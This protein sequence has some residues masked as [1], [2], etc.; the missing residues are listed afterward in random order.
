MYVISPSSRIS[1]C[2]PVSKCF[3]LSQFAANSKSYLAQ[4]TT[5]LLQPGNHTL[6]SM[7]LVSN[8]TNL[9]MKPMVAGTVNIVC[10]PSGK[11]RFRMVLYA[12]IG[13]MFFT[14]CV[15]NS[16]S[17]V[18]Y[19]I[20]SR[21]AFLGPSITASGTAIHVDNAN[22]TIHQCFF[23]SYLYGSIQNT[24]S[25]L[26]S[27]YSVR[28]MTSWNGG[29]IIASRSSV[30]IDQ[31]TF[32]ENRA[33]F[34]G[35]I[36]TVES[37]ITITNS[38]F[39]FNT[40][41]STHSATVAGGSAVCAV[42]SIVSIYNSTLVKNSVYYGYTLGGAL[43]IISSKLTIA[44]SLMNDNRAIDSGGGVH[45]V[46]SDVTMINCTCRKNRADSG[47]L[48]A[49]NRSTLMI[50]STY[51]GDNRASINGGFV[52]AFSSKVTIRFTLVKYAYAQLGGVIYSNASSITIQKS[53]VSGNLA[54]I[55]GGVIYCFKN[56]DIQA[57]ESLF[58]SNAVEQN[59][60]VV[61][62]SKDSYVMAMNCEF[63]NNTASNGAVFRSA[64]SFITI[65]KSTFRNN[66]AYIEG[67][68]IAVLNS[69]LYISKT[70]FTMNRALVGGVLR[71]KNSSLILHTLLISN[72]SATSGG[73]MEIVASNSTLTNVSIASNFGR[74][75]ILS[76]LWSHVV[77]MNRT[78][79][80]SNVGSFLAV[81][82]IIE[83]LGYTLFK[84]NFITKDTF[85]SNVYQYGG[86]L[87]LINSSLSLGGEYII[88]IN[89]SAMNGGAIHA[90][91]SKVNSNGRLIA[92]RNSAQVSGGAM[93]LENSDLQCNGTLQFY[94]N[95]ALK[96]GGGIES[97]SSSVSLNSNC[98]LLFDKNWAPA[99]SD[100]TMDKL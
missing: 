13:N 15:D 65:T 38:V 90:N 6:D 87:T 12:S 31:S 53:M 75:G 57:N 99:G 32:K 92:F 74:K 5:L 89:N 42:K 58:T 71:V 4:N 97:V 19:L 43:A 82:S 64:N 20:L 9:S 51:I 96:R 37:N 80:T 21:L 95:V 69:M 70:T 66:A 10:T 62:V 81:D 76:L 61:S 48:F 2:Q 33:Q 50:L 91:M 22:V 39:D 41:N 55:D 7:L 77:F 8:I 78:V 29:A 88:F 73:V 93:Y 85:F 83:F 84:N 79:V 59:G 3:T 14:H 26:R 28:D 68:T 67:G 16:V 36:Y 24:T 11:L 35:A 94:S 56:C 1:S 54:M 46:F 17:N 44:N 45:A 100:I 25:T 23:S 40:A 47:G 27:A 18:K 63:F 34:G 30:V 86:A 52:V 49:V 72:N 60:G 98:S